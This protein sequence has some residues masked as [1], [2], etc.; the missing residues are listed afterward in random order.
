MGGG[1]DLGEDRTT[2]DIEYRHEE[3]R[4]DEKSDWNRRKR[5]FYHVHASAAVNFDPSREV[6]RVI[7]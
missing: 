4:I 7:R 1:T 2:S 5:W 3:K 6:G